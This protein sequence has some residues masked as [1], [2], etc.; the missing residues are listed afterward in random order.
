MDSFSVNL[1]PDQYAA[2]SQKIQAMPGYTPAMQTAGVLPEV[3][4]VQLRY[5]VTK[6]TAGA[7]VSF[8][9]LKKPFF[10]S[11]ALIRGRVLSMMGVS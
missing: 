6:T 9:V 7:S 8:A 4:G 11:A 3:S 10:V 2:L 1:T 5:S